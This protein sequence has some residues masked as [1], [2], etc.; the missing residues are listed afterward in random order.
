MVEPPKAGLRSG[1]HNHLNSGRLDVTE[2]LTSFKS[3]LGCYWGECKAKVPLFAFT[4]LNQ[5]G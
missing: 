4:S 5:G 2:A 1:I 3:I